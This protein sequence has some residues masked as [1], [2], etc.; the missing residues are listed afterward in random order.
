MVSLHFFELFTKNRT[1]AKI[2]KENIISENTLHG[3]DPTKLI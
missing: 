3:G 1:N 2:K